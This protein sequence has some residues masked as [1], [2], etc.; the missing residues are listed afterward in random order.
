[1]VD[2]FPELSTTMFGYAFGNFAIV[3]A[4]VLA[5]ELGHLIV[6]FDSIILV[7]ILHFLLVGEQPLASVL[8]HIGF[9]LRIRVDLF[10]N[11]VL[12][13]LLD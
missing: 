6:Y 8:N 5:L 11:G 3:L 7:Q 1:M 9:L 12:L 4:Y 2:I 13:L 10:R